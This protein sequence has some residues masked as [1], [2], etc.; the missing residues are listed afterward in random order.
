MTGLSDHT[1]SP[2]STIIII[3]I[4]RKQPA[5]P[6]RQCNTDRPL[7]RF[8]ERFFNKIRLGGGPGVP[9]AKLHGCGI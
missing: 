8:F 3:I 4:T 6:P 1:V 9:H 2:S 7:Q 5:S